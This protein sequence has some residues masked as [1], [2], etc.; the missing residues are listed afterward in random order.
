MGYIY[1][2]YQNERFLE[3]LQDLP[4]ILTG[5]ILWNLH[6]VSSMT[7]CFQMAHQQMMLRWTT[8]RR[9]TQKFR[10]LVPQRQLSMPHLMNPEYVECDVSVYGQL[11][12]GGTVD[13]GATVHW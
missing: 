4:H 9:Y 2:G 3:T 12:A 6:G 11:I 7:N 5:W 1:F 13:L 8:V 10:Y